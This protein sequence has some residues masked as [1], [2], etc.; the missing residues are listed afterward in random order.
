[1]KGRETIPTANEVNG[2]RPPDESNF[3]SIM[4][5]PRQWPSMVAPSGTIGR[6]VDLEN[7]AV[8]LP[9]EVMMKRCIVPR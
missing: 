2:A 3:A 5:K 9:M 8:A 4:S 7:S 6:Q 1:M